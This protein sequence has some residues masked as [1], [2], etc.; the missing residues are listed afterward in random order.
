MR[1]LFNPPLFKPLFKPPLFRPVR[2]RSPPLSPCRSEF[3]PSND[4][5]DD[6]DVL[7]PFPTSTPWWRLL[8]AVERGCNEVDNRPSGVS[9]RD[10]AAEP[11]GEML[12]PVLN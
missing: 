8:F 4:D 12:I 6:D 1:L 11:V 9:V 5:E 3:K 2:V 10:W 7:P